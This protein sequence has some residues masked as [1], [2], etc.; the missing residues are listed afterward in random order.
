M[1]KKGKFKCSVCKRSFGMAA[2]LGRHMAT[3]HSSRARRTAATGGAKRVKRTATAIR[4]AGMDG[5]AAA[6]GNIQ[7]YRNDLAAQRATLDSQ[8]AALDWALATLGAV[9]PARKVV[10]G[11]GQRGSGYRS[12]SLKAHIQKVLQARGG[13]MTVKDVTTAVRKAGYKSKNKTL[14]K[15]V[16]VALSEMPGV[17]KVGRGTFRGT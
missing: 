5:L 3:I 11:D 8:L 6:V 1:A 7:L 2:H 17:K 9:A 16:G 14:D 13:G 4:S 12:G 15:S 10:A